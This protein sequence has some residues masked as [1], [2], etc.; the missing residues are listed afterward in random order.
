MA[1]PD[2][3]GTLPAM[4]AAQTRQ[5]QDRPLLTMYDDLTGARTELS[6]ATADNWAS[7]TANLLVEEFAIGP[8]ATVDLDLAGHWTTVA[9][10]LACWKIGAAV[11]DG[12]DVPPTLVCCHESR[13]DRYQHGPVVVVGDGL[14]AEPVATIPTR[15]EVVLLGED[16]HAFADDY[17]DPT[18]AATTPAVAAPAGVLDQSAVLS[19][20]SAWRDVLGDRHRVAIAAPLDTPA[21]LVLLAGVLL[22][23]GGIVADR[24]APEAPPWTR[25]AS[26]RVTAAAGHPDLAASA[27]DAVTVFDLELG[28]RQS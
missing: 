23:G 3:A 28:T 4:L 6:Y 13:A 24:P 26:E 9:V 12:G 25:W 21:A 22:A 27:P 10:T 8:G 20:A 11:R 19:R 16:V 2:V 18:V 15:D 14:R 7:K 5:L 17:D 1:C